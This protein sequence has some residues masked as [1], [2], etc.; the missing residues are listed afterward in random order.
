[1]LAWALVDRQAVYPGGL[2]GQGRGDRK[3][4]LNRA[5]LNPENSRWIGLGIG[6]GGHKGVAIT[7]LG[8][9]PTAKF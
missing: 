8:K 5:G 7:A 3:G 9:Q 4:H 6:Q 1:M 2:P